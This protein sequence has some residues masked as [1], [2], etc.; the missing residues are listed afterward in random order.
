MSRTPAIPMDNP[1]HGSFE[2]EGAVYQYHAV[3]VGTDDHQVKEMT[4]GGA[5]DGTFI[6]G[7]AQ[8]DALDEESVNVVYAGI[9]WGYASGAV[10]RDGPLA[11]IYSGT[12][13]SN[14]RFITATN[15]PAGMMLAGIALEDAA[16][17]EKFKLFLLRTIPNITT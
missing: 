4:T 1:F 3:I 7:V 17:G 16:A 14:G 6:E 2:A 5:A 10:T 15:V 8:H 13:A 12:T 9:T 11:A